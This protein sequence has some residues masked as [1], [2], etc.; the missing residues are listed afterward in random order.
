MKREWRLAFAMGGGLVVVAIVALAAVLQPWA[1]PPRQDG[2]AEPAGAGKSPGGS[3]CAS[4]S[5]PEA[6][7]LARRGG[8]SVI[9]ANGSLTGKT[10]AHGQIYYKMALR[11]VTTLSGPAVASGSAGWIAS[12]QGP[13]GPIPGADAGALWATDGHLFAIAWPARETGTAVGPVLRVAPVVHGQVIFSSA[14]CWDTTGLPTQLYR[15][16]LAEI[17]GSNSYARAAKDG[18]HAVPLARVRRLVG[19]DSGA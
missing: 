5:L 19:R 7:A 14:G 11:S 16:P 8:A 6:L 13:G 15:G 1:A 2:A 4:V 17:P 9:V 12:P 3:G 10:A 18:F